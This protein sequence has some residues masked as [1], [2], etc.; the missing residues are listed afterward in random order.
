M[1]EYFK[2][3]NNELTYLNEV[4][5]ICYFAVN[6]KATISEASGFI[7]KTAGLGKS[8]FS[9]QM[10]N[11]IRNAISA[12]RAV[13]SKKEIDDKIDALSS[14]LSTAMMGLSNLAKSQVSSGVALTAM[15][16]RIGKMEKNLLKGQAGIKKNTGR[17]R[18]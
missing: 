15:S 5:Q 11:Q 4:E 6:D 17:R 1:N 16:F 8:A 13:K 3:L 7:A 2:T 18:R 10:L 14:A 12:L 9:K